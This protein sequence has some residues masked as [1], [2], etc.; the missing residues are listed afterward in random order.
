MIEFVSILEINFDINK[1]IIKEKNYWVT[2]QKQ[3]VLQQQLV[4]QDVVFMFHKNA[5][6]TQ[7]TNF[8]DKSCLVM[9]WRQYKLKKF[10]FSEKL[11][12]WLF[13][14]VK[15]PDIKGIQNSTM[16]APVEVKRSI[17]SCFCVAF[18]R[19]KL[20]LFDYELSHKIRHFHS[21]PSFTL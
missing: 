9:S 16:K 3:K 11:L 19:Q 5:R 12:V 6:D 7:K 20:E 14:Q 21:L 18:L 17:W 1:Y 2:N 15:S 8:F 4:F 13:D 10:G